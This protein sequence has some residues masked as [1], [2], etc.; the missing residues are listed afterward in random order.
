MSQRLARFITKI[1]LREG[2]VVLAHELQRVQIRGEHFETQAS[3]CCHRPQL[4]QV[5]PPFL[6][7]L[8][9]LLLLLPL[10]HTTE[11]ELHVPGSNGTEKMQ[12]L[13]TC[14]GMVDELRV[15]QSAS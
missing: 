10:R 12:S 2:L 13:S 5:A 14:Q 4:A 9:L 7:L 15:S 11:A 3:V 8:L 6:L 1:Q